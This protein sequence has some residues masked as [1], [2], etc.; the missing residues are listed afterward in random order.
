MKQ[1]SRE[2]RAREINHEDIAV[3]KRTTRGGHSNGSGND[4]RQIPVMTHVCRQQQQQEQQQDAAQQQQEEEQ[5]IMEEYRLCRWQKESLAFPA[6]EESRVVS[7]ET[8]VCGSNTG[9]NA[10]G[11]CTPQD[12]RTPEEGVSFQVA[13]PS[14][15]ATNIT[16]LCA[17]GCF[18]SKK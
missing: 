8:A 10:G 2:K 13:S 17:R 12:R 18:A 6:N 11:C 5:R 15:R 3:M 14:L 1:L 16:E 7:T 4:A 9:S